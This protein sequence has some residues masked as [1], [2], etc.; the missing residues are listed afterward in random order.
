[1]DAPLSVSGSRKRSLQLQILTHHFAAVPLRRANS[2]LSAY[3]LGSGST[4]LNSISSTSDSNKSSSCTSNACT[5]KISLDHQKAGF[6]SLLV[7]HEEDPQPIHN[8]NVI[9]EKPL[10][11]L[12]ETISSSKTPDGLIQFGSREIMASF[13]GSGLKL[14]EWPCIFAPIDGPSDDEPPS[15]SPNLIIKPDSLPDSEIQGHAIINPDGNPCLFPITFCTVHKCSGYLRLEEIQN[16]ESYTRVVDHASR[17]TKVTHMFNNCILEFPP[18]N[19]QLI[20]FKKKNQDDDEAD[21]VKQD[22]SPPPPPPRSNPADELEDFLTKCLNCCKLLHKKDV[23]MYM[24]DAWYCCNDCRYW[25]TTEAI[26]EARI[27]L[28]IVLAK[29]QRRHYRLKVVVAADQNSLQ[30]SSTDDGDDDEA[31]SNKK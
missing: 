8:K 11:P 22:N 23:Y 18:N 24:G 1:M 26:E 3:L 10:N 14:H 15:F 29:I 2:D 21:Q 28:A 30:K 20:V 25:K 12:A 9:L 31:P 13:G 4:S 16:S 6:K 5:P 7:H 27:A 17:R 19:D